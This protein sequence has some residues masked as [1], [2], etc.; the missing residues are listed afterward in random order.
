MKLTIQANV[1]SSKSFCSRVS[2]LDAW[3]LISARP[4]RCYQGQCTCRSLALRS[5]DAALVTDDSAM[6]AECPS[7]LTSDINVGH[8]ELTGRVH[9][10]SLEWKGVGVWQ[11]YVNRSMNGWMN[12][13]MDECSECEFHFFHM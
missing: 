11:R 9:G 4:S 6:D 5:E 1:N 2:V 3:V 10:C 7:I 8:K 13:E 12:G